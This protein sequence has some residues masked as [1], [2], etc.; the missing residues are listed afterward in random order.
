MAWQGCISKN[1]RPEDV[2]YVSVL[3]WPYVAIMIVT[4]IVRHEHTVR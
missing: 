4:V 2:K 1:E 3:R